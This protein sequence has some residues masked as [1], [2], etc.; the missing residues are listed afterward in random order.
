MDIQTMTLGMLCFMCATQLQVARDE[1]G[2]VFMM[3]VGFIGMLLGLVCIGAG[4][5]S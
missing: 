5:F 3:L 1:P 4:V 2:Y